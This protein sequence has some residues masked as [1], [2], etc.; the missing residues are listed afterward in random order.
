MAAHRSSVAPSAGAPRSEEAELAI[1]GAGPIGLEAALAAAEAGIPFVLLERGE[2]VASHVRDWR[3]VPLFTPWDLDVSPRQRAALAAAAA[4]PPA[5]SDCPTGGELIAQV[6]E[7]LSRLPSVAPHLRLGTRVVAIG[8]EGLVKPVEIG[9]PRRAAARFRLLLEDEHGERVLLARSVFDCTGSYELPGWIGDGGIPAPGERALGARVVRRL[10][11]LDVEAAL[12]SGR[13]ILLVGAGHSAQTA[14]VALAE[15]ARRAPRTHATGALITWAVRR[16]RPAIAPD[17]ADPLP[18]RRRLHAAAQALLEG[19]DP[20]VAPRAGAT[21]IGLTAEDGAIRATLRRCHPSG[22][23]R[24]PEEPEEL[25]VDRVLALVGASGDEGLYRELQVHACY[26]TSGPMRLAAQLLASS[27]SDCMA[28]P[29]AGADVLVTTEPGFFLLGSKSYG[30]HSAFLLRAGWQQVDD[31]I[32][33]LRRGS[34]DAPAE[35]RTV[36]PQPAATQANGV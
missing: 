2:R 31:A 27:S 34:A 32:S 9:T 15:L 25:V 10:P 8:R 20:A 23:A 4:E 6:L 1:L 16:L 35:P 18:A 19:A 11:D 3:H 7:P 21:A 17:P 12:W 26:A 5:G 14:A 29:S 28:Q 33:L 13:R 36:G 30:R 24:G 22:S